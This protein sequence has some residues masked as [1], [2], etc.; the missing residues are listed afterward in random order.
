VLVRGLGKRIGRRMRFFIFQSG[1]RSGVY[2]VRSLPLNLMSASIS[3]LTELPT[4]TLEYVLLHLP[5]Q[6][7]IKMEVVREVVVN[8]MR[9]DFDFVVLSRSV[10][11]SR[12]LFALR[13]PFSI[14]VNSSLLV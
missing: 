3:C 12:T 10:D 2:Y 14:D 4:E 7:I 1:S 5:G 13:P 6:D 11:T 8:P 9:H